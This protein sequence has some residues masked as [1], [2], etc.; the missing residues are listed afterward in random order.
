MRAREF[1]IEANLDEA[2]PKWAKGA[3]AG[4]AL[5]GA[6]VAGYNAMHKEPTVAAPSKPQENPDLRVLAQTIW[7]EARSHGTKGMLAIGN[8][9]KNRAEDT[10]HS[11]LFGQGIRGVSLKPKQ[12]S[13]WNKGD[14][15]Q[16]RLKEILQF[17]KLIHLK[18]SPDGT[19]F[20]QWYK[21][22]KNTGDYLDYKSWIQAKEIAKKI[23][24]GT[25]PDPTHGAV[26]YHT[27]EGN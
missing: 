25:A 15:N 4:A 9:I 27:N 11:R 1:T 16:D 12:F 23:L 26:Y 17:D 6:G 10:K 3:L 24:N 5:A 14:P 2:M 19:P 13:C 8:V 22:F 18:K 21:K 7:G 20:D